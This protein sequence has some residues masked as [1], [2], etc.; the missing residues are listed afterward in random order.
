MLINKKIISMKNSMI[1]FLTLL[2]CIHSNAQLIFD[3]GA[4]S[5]KV[6]TISLNIKPE[7]KFINLSPSRFDNFQYLFSIDMYVEKIKP[8]QSAETV[9]DECNISSYHAYDSLSNVLNEKN[10]NKHINELNKI[11]NKLDPKTDK[12]CIEKINT[13][14]AKTFYKKPLQFSLKKN[15][16]ITVTIKRKDKTKLD[17]I[18]VRT[19]KTP[20]KSPWTILYG[21]ILIP[22]YW[23]PTPN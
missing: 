17:K 13:L 4:E 3:L 11:L 7:I 1:T 23:D 21:N 5:I 8:F 12:A 16:L 18:W 10:V 20:S 19:F 9:S 2:V 15:Q 22:K 14:I 6:I